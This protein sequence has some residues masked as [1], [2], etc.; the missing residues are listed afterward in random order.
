LIVLVRVADIRAYE[1][2]VQ[3]LFSSDPNVKRSESLVVL[4]EVK[5]ELR[6]PLASG[7]GR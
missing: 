2:V 4:E 3:R 6:I 5:R 1:A 7:N